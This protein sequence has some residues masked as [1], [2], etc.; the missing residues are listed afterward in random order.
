MNA[1]LALKSLV[2]ALVLLVLPTIRNLFLEPRMSTPHIDLLIIQVSLTA[3]LIG[4][5]GLGFST[6]VAIFT[7]SLCIF[8]SGV[9][10]VDS[11]YAYGTLSLPPGEKI[12]E[13]YLRLGLVQTISGLFGAPFWSLILSLVLKSR[14]LPLGLPF[15]SCA[16]L[17]GAALVGAGALKRWHG[18]RP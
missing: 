16:G 3:S 13:L 1:A 18:T 14:V 5:A 12:T 7:V 15:W 8:T 10:L 11:L 6:S 2:S 9:G 17:F 4:T